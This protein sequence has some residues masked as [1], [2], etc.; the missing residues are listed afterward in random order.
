MTKSKRNYSLTKNKYL[1]LEKTALKAKIIYKL[2]TSLMNKKKH[3]TKEL[4]S[5]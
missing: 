1:N 3:K 2:K 5:Y 4:E